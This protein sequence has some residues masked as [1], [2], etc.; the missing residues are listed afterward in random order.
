[1]LRMAPGSP[2]QDAHWHAS[3]ARGHLAKWVATYRAGVVPQ[4]RG[5]ACERAI[6]EATRLLQQRLEGPPAQDEQFD[7]ARRMGYTV[8]SPSCTRKGGYTHVVMQYT[9]VPGAPYP[10]H[11]AFLL[12]RLLFSR[13]NHRIK[14]RG[15]TTDDTGPGGNPPGFFCGC[16]RVSQPSM[17]LLRFQQRDRARLVS[18]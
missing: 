8:S 5:G 16:L 11:G 1:M 9:A 18:V 12:T 15:T 6:R 2:T 4:G 14:R 10:F 17:R 7:S 3:G 13:N